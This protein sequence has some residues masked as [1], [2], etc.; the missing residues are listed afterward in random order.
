MQPAGTPTRKENQKRRTQSGRERER[1]RERDTH[2][3]LPVAE[4]TVEKFAKRLPH[5]SA[6]WSSQS[7]T[8]RG[9][10]R[11]T[12]TSAVE[13]N[14]RNGARVGADGGWGGDGEGTKRRRRRSGS[15][16]RH[17]QRNRASRHYAIA[18]RFSSSSFPC[19][20]QLHAT[21][22]IDEWIPSSYGWKNSS[23]FFFYWCWAM[24]MDVQ[25]DVKA[26][27]GG[28]GVQV[29]FSSNPIFFLGVG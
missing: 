8:V 23:T 16:G 5:T 28:N 14:E 4:D 11:A 22:H 26:C 7:S 29:P 21:L 25:Y 10:S 20:Y 6:R 18:T 1:E 17:S 12:R 3:H 24:S 19:N 15:S 27:W 13:R 2:P 9:P